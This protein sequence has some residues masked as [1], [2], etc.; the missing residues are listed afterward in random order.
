VIERARPLAG[1]RILVTRA[2]AQVGSLRALL[3]AEG[4]VVVE[5]PTIRIGPA[6]DP[7]PLDG[8]IARLAE[9]RWVVF[10]SRNGV[11]ALCDRL[12]VLGQGPEA[13]RSARL[14]A[15][16]PGTADALRTAG[17]RAELEPAEFRAEGLVRAFE[18]VDLRGVRVL[19]PRAA[20]ARDA[21][22]DG[23][24]ARGA[25]VDVVPAYR[26]DVERDHVPE[27]RRRLVAEPVDAVTFTSS[28]TVRNFVELLGSDAKRA[29][30]AALVACIGPVTAATARACGLPVGVVADDY[31]IPGLVAALRVAFA[32]SGRSQD[33][34]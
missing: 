32:G 2:R 3:E 11:A 23:L 15:I 16:G 6:E 19:L 22:P 24:R 31:T 5:F 7:V 14:A 13:L 30:D 33:D 25:I 26:T 4:A 18:G 17:L 20:A 27:M 9:Y 8:A 28:S 10:T 1:R 21:L 34:R 29:L 12:R